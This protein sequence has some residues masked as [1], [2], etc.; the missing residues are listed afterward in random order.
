M[1]NFRD[2]RFLQ[3]AGYVLAALSAAVLIIWAVAGASLVTQYQVATTQSVEDE[4]GDTIESTVLVDQFQF[5][6]LPD[7]GYDGAAPF[8]GG[9]GGL[10]VVCFFL[11][12]RGRKSSPD[13]VNEHG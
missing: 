10:A 11:A 8:V 12:R 7:R 13:E 6:L 5:G 1:Q 2:P 9:F 3:R 4:F